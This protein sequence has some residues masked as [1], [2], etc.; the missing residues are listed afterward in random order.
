MDYP[1]DPVALLALCLIVLSGAVATVAVSLYFG[2]SFLSSL[3]RII[4]KVP[5]GRIEPWRGADHIWRR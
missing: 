5:P 4:W 2:M 3:L 1:F